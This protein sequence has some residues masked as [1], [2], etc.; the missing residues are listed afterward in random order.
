VPLPSNRVDSVAGN[1]AAG[2]AQQGW[3]GTVHLTSML[4]NLRVDQAPST[5]MMQAVAPAVVNGSVQFDKIEGTLGFFRDR[6]SR[7]YEHLDRQASQTF[8]LWRI[9]VAF[10]FAVLSGGLILIF[11]GRLAEAAASLTASVLVYFIQRIFQQREDQYRT[12]A[13]KKNAHL[14]YGSR[15]LVAVQTIAAIE[16]PG[17]RLRCQARLAVALSEQI[18]EG[19]GNTKARAKQPRAKQQKKTASS[20]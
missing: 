5:F 16:E 7:Q 1:E 12:L 15:W 13:D 11:M 2:F 20:S 17:A 6:L 19:V 10:G 18:Q 8:A 4:Q 14:E 3:A 9:C